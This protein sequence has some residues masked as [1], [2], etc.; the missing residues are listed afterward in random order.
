[1]T[2]AP[3]GDPPTP[4]PVNP[5]PPPA[6]E[7]SFTDQLKAAAG[8]GG[9]GSGPLITSPLP[10]QPD[11]NP[12]PKR[13]VSKPKRV[14]KRVRMALGALDIDVRIFVKGPNQQ[15]LATDLEN[16]TAQIVKACFK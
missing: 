6:V 7:T 15:Q 16:A 10:P 8:S 2:T 9:S 14:E 3:A 12:T 4:V 1:M 11:E 13:T 5:F